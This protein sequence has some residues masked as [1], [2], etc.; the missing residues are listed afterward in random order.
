MYWDDAAGRYDQVFPN[1][2]VGQAQREAVWRELEKVFRPG[3]HILEI[4][5]GTGIDAVHLA[6]SGVRVRAC[7]I[8]PQ[9]IELARR[10]LA[11]SEA[12]AVAD[13]RVLA[14]EELAALRDG[15]RFDGAFSNFSG[16]NCVQDLSGVALNLAS[17]LKGG[18]RLLICVIGRWVP[19]EFVWH[20]AHSEFRKPFER[21]Q[22]V[23]VSRDG[24]VKTYHHSVAAIER[25]FHPHFRLRRL[26]GIG[27]VMPPGQFE[28][29]AARFPDLFKRLAQTDR[30]L[31]GWPILRRMG[32]CTLLEFERE[33]A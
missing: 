19:W 13:F 18:A 33:A 25:A 16:L 31:G 2:I 9:M 8:S 5:C 28:R 7:D 6:E 20:F 14:T 21:F 3:Q 4:N 30:L 24:R 12:R 17:L 26:R 10:R 22:R 29:W 32:D 23:S 11:S 15:P 1:K 27:V